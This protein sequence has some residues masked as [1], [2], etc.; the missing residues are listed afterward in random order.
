MQYPVFCFLKNQIKVSD[1]EQHYEQVNKGIMVNAVPAYNGLKPF[2][3]K[4][5]GYAGYIV[6][7]D[8]VRYSVP[9]NP[10]ALR[11]GRGFA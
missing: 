11:D 6:E 8:D 1:I 3:T 2:Q 7:I 4:G 5:K 10:D 9:C